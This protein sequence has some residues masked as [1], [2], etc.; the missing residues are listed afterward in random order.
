VLGVYESLVQAVRCSKYERRCASEN[1]VVNT[2]ITIV[3]RSRLISP[4]RYR[5]RSYAEYFFVEIDG[6]RCISNPIDERNVKFVK[7]SLERQSSNMY[8]PSDGS[9]VT[10]QLWKGKYPADLSC[11]SSQVSFQK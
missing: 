5:E 7:P 10:L 8:L 3:S 11:P 4:C 1:E 2:P 6:G 9:G